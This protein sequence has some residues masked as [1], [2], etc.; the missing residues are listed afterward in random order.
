MKVHLHVILAA[1]ILVVGPISA[2]SAEA[3]KVK[4]EK[5]YGG[6][7]IERPISLQIAPDG[8][9]RRFL[10]EQTGKIRIL[11]GDEAATEAKVFFDL[12][13]VMAVEKDFEE[14]L[15]G[16][17]FHP[18]FREN[19]RFY[20]TF[21]RQG[22]KRL[23]L[24]EFGV[25]K[26]DPDA[27]DPSTER[28]LLEVQEPEWNHN[29]GNLFFGPKDGM[30][31]LCTGDGGVKNGLHLL[32]QK[33]SS[34]CGKVLR[35]DVETRTGS[36]P[37]GIPS[38]NPF[39]ETANAAPEIWAYGLRNPWGAA[40]DPAT[41]LFYLADVGQDLYEEI[42]LIEKGGN[43]GW[44]Y[45]E[46]SHTFPGREPLLAALGQQ[47]QVAPPA[48]LVLTAPIHE[49][50]RAE[51]LSITGGYVYHGRAIPALQGCFLYGDWRF[52]NLWALHYDAAAKKV[53]ANHV[54]DKPADPANPTVQP[55]GIFPDEEGEALYL[56]WRGG[57]FRLVPGA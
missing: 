35:I 39:V 3:P 36:R 55:T 12:S 54:V 47:K 30:L 44:N 4:L 29:S 28:V 32:S 27:A 25:S 2:G 56:D 50:N 8:S 23:V 48:D 19:G 9:G 52:G 22:P 33:L 53:A 40:I 15:L 57:I 49:Y 41:G 31:Y 6:L 42:N 21:S 18:D 24:A 37:Y 5:I 17:A 7:V 51:G 26:T 43:Y 1:A 20:L 13:S 14:G 46:A 11:P 38:D 45:Q 34:W 10:V 16:L